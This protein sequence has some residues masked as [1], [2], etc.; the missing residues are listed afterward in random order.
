MQ[1]DWSGRSYVCVTLANIFLDNIRYDLVESRSTDPGTLAGSWHGTHRTVRPNQ[2]RYKA[3][4]VVVA[5]PY[6]LNSITRSMSIEEVRGLHPGGGG[7]QVIGIPPPALRIS[8]WEAC[9]TTECRCGI[10]N[11]FEQILTVVLSIT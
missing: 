2:F 8:P 5:L 1:P 10:F 4:T 9:P 7:Q 11:D 6:E 3:I